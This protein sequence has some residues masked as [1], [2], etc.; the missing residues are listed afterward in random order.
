MLGDAETVLKDHWFT[1]GERTA[2]RVKN[3]GATTTAEQEANIKGLYGKNR[4]QF[5]A[6][7]KLAMAGSE[8]A[9]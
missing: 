8:V 4:M 2:A 3:T 7:F 9:K 6:G 5:V 1:V